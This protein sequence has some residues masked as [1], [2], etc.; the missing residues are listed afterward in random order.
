V[1]SEDIHDGIN[2]TDARVDNKLRLR[3]RNPPVG[4]VSETTANGGTLGPYLG[5]R[6]G[7]RNG[8]KMPT[9]MKRVLS[10]VRQGVRNLNPC[11]V[12]HFG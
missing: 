11:K 3:E 9:G 5:W 6:R 4:A 7:Q 10:E 2:L 1:G 12:E 8:A